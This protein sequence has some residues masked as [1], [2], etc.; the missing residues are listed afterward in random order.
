MHETCSYGLPGA[1]KEMWRKQKSGSEKD[2]AR[3]WKRMS[4]GSE[5]N[6]CCLKG[7]QVRQRGV[8]MAWRMVDERMCCFESGYLSI[9]EELTAMGKG[10]ARGELENIKKLSL[11]SIYS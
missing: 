4:S 9:H 11:Q 5:G 3:V 7:S 6:S 2:E 1:K 10:F 8:L